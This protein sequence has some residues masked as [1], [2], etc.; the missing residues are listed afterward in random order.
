MQSGT[1]QRRRAGT[2]IKRLDYRLSVGVG[3]LP[4]ALALTRFFALKF[5]PTPMMSISTQL[6][7]TS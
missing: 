6:C 5:T 7:A 3:M 2:L 4:I 1:H